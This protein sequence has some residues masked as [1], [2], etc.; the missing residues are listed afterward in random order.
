[1]DIENVMVAGG[2]TLGSQV[3]WQTAFMGFNVRLYDAFPEGIERAKNFHEQF[4][5]LFLNTRD[6]P[7]EDVE[8]TKARLTYTTD[9]A[10]AVKD[11]DYVIEAVLEVLDLKRKIFAD[12]DKMAPAHA[13]LATNSAAIDIEEDAF[14][15]K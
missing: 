11:A 12:L 6:T 8:A 4:A 15:G 3:A 1:M 13:I 9:M 2:G 14:G 10:E 5:D 7:K